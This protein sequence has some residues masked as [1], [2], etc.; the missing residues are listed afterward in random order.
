LRVYIPLNILEWYL[1]K[2]TV[3]HSEEMGYGPNK[4]GRRVTTAL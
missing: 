2:V 4:Q 1:K 3:S